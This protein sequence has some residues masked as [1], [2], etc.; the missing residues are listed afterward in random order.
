MKRI[1][2]K[3][4]ECLLGI[5]IGDAMGMPVEI[6]TPEEILAATDGKGV[7]GFIDPV[8]RRIHDTMD[9]KAGDTTDDW[10]LTRIVAESLIAMGGYDQQHQ[11]LMHIKAY[12]ESQF[13]WGGTTTK[14]IESLIEGRDPSL[15]LPAPKPGTGCGN[16]VAMKIAPIALYVTARCKTAAKVPLRSIV[17]EHGK[18]THP[19]V[20]AS[21]AAYAL[22]FGISHVLTNPLIKAGGWTMDRTR[23]SF[24][25]TL[26]EEIVDVERHLGL[27]QGSPDAVS[28]K[29][30]LASQLLKDPEGLREQVGTGCISIESV[31]FALATFA[32]HFGSFKDGVL[33]AVNAGGDTDTIASMVGA[34]IGANGGGE[35]YTAR[36]VPL[37]WQD[38]L[39]DK[40]LTAKSL[41]S[42]LY[43]I[44]VE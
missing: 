2:A 17:M 43:E 15:P 10:Q 11:A 35:S 6:M 27:P 8:Q 30:I 33:E 42:R 26:I 7:Q 38:E 41:G 24:M 40:G 31:P 34:L 22:A 12:E 1:K 9:L 21:I 18:L 14:G 37:V 4:E 3:F 20:R 44:A 39:H 5:Q 32:R 25:S 13:G 16:G 19:D 28:R 23:E 36:S 29:L